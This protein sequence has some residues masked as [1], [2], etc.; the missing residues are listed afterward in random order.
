[1]G[2]INDTWNYLDKILP[3]DGQG[4]TVFDNGQNKE[5]ER[6]FYLEFWLEHKRVLWCSEFVEKWKPR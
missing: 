6:T 2:E 5:L 3:E 4:I 1:M